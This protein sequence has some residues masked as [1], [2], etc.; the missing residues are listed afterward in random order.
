MI[1][2]LASPV[3]IIFLLA[4]GYIYKKE[5]EKPVETKEATELDVRD[6]LGV[7]VTFS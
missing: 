4:G 5:F 3:I 6:E 2:L 1:L 7:S